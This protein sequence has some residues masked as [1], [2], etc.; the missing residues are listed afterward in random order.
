MPDRG[1]V[2]F[3]R[4]RRP[5]TLSGYKSER[6]YFSDESITEGGHYICGAGAAQGRDG[7]QQIFSDSLAG[8]HRFQEFLCELGVA[9]G[10]F[11]PGYEDGSA[12]SYE[13][14]DVRHHPHHSTLFRQVLKQIYGF[15]LTQGWSSPVPAA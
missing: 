4:R 14:G 12:A 9:V 5:A 11:A 10:G 3:L 6:S 1:E 2:P 7:V 8:P 13:G 15:G